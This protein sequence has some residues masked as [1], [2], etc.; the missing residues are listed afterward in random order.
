MWT[1]TLG[2]TPWKM[3]NRRGFTLARP[4]IIGG[5]S[6]VL[7]GNTQ[8]VRRGFSFFWVVD[9]FTTVILANL[10]RIS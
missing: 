7:N 8:R 3:F 1:E 2:L 5:V 4:T 6:L 10:V 9:T